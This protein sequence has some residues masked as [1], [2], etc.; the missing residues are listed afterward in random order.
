[1]SREDRLLDVAERFIE[2]HSAWSDDQ[3]AKKITEDYEEALLDM[4]ATFASGDMPAAVRPLDAAVSALSDEW[5]AFAG[6][7]VTERAGYVTQANPHPKSTFWAAVARVREALKGATFTQPVILESIP[8][9]VAQKCTNLQICEIYAHE[10]KGP[11]MVRGVPR[12][13]LVQREIETPGSVLPPGFVHP[14]ESARQEQEAA[15]EARREQRRLSREAARPP[16]PESI[17]DLLR[18]GLTVA[19]CCATAEVTAAEVLAEAARLGI[20]P[21]DPVNLTA[22]RAPGEP[23][24]SEEDDRALDYQSGK[25]QR[26]AEPVDADEFPEVDQDEPLDFD[27]ALTGDEIMEPAE[28]TPEQKNARIIELGDQGIGAVEIARMLGLKTQS[29]AA[30][31]R[32]HRARQQQEPVGAMS[33]AAEET[34]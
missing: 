29:V 15:S 4:V 25:L 28:L 20:T 6:D 27:T 5:I 18:Q 7:P 8:Q 16:C 22:M 32:H 17:E 21:A 2:V 34:A 13:D 14:R 30:T 26:V 10:G 24:I 9:L 31:L 3:N 33:D 12:P 23:Q 19:Q 1:M 11:F